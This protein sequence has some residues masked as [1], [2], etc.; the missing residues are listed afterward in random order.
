MAEMPSLELRQ[1][2]TAVHAA[3]EKENREKEI[4]FQMLSPLEMVQYE[5]A[6]NQAESGR[7]GARKFE[8]IMEQRYGN[9]EQRERCLEAQRILAKEG[10]DSKTMHGALKMF[11]EFS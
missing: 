6:L 2:A 3:I 11:Y 4:K 1:A 9:P 7:T 8:Q 5:D 10:I